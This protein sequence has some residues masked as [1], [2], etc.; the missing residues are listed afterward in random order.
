M[1]WRDM[2]TK[3]EA[4]IVEWADIWNRIDR[5]TIA[6]RQRQRRA[7]YLRAK[8]RLERVQKPVDTVAEAH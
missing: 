5:D 6:G 3:D 4:D 7:I 2:L 1:D 8:K